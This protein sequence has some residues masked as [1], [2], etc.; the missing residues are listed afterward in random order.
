M[1]KIYQPLEDGFVQALLSWNPMKSLE[2]MELMSGPQLT[3]M[4]ANMLIQACPVLKYIG[5]VSTW[6]RVDREEMEAVQAEIRRRNLDLV[7]E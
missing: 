6:G 1:N 3:I 4:A 5:K 2:R 7:L